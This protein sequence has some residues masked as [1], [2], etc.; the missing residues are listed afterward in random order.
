ML[1]EPGAIQAVI[2][3]APD[4]VEI[5]VPGGDKE[6]PLDRGAVKP[7]V[8]PPVSPARWCGP[9]PCSAWMVWPAGG[10]GVCQ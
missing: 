8:T 2:A 3:A 9:T 7:D 4:V 10:P 5:A 1:Q 6:L